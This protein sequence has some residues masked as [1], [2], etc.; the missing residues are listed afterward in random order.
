LSTVYSLEDLYDM[1]EVILVDSFN[2]RVA[3]KW[4]DKQERR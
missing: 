1:L 4:L 3:R 2:E